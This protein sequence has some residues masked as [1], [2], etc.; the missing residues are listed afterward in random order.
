MATGCPTT[1]KSVHN[2]RYQ[3]KWKH[4][5]QLNSKISGGINYNQVSDD[6]YYR[7][8]YG[9]K[10][11]RATSTSTVKHGSITATNC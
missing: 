8:F 7:D 1:K 10:T 9:A 4:Q 6:D 5:Q 3:F 2:N 11:S